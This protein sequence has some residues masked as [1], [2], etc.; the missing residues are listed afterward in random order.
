[1]NAQ[2]RI[3][4]ILREER[5]LARSQM[6]DELRRQFSHREYISRMELMEAIAKADKQEEKGT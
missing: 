3:Q 1:M 4:R 2:D 6:A 5:D